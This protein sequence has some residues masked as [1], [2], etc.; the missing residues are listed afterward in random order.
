MVSS[1]G[2]DMNPKKVQAIEKLQTPRTRKE[3]G[4]L[5]GMMAAL[6]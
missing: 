1:Q 5:A 2:I 4:K 6:S 3:I